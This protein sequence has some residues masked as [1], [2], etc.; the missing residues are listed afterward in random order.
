[1]RQ[2]EFSVT[3]SARMVIGAALLLATVAMVALVFYPC[4]YWSQPTLF[5]PV[6]AIA[7]MTAFVGPFLLSFAKRRPRRPSLVLGGLF[8][9]AGS[10]C[11]V[12]SVFGAVSISGTGYWGASSCHSGYYGDYSLLG[13]Q[14]MAFVVSVGSNS[15][16]G[17]LIGI[18]YGKSA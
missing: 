18:G 2:S 12:V 3:R 11:W 17:L 8:T 4:T 5:I 6:S 16:G 7:P 15:L 10:L 13:L 14:I 9:L 1:M